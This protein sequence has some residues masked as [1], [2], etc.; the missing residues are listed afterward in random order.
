M[1][2]SQNLSDRFY[3]NHSAVVI[4]KRFLLIRSLRLLM[5]NKGNNNY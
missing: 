5:N 4:K 2:V 3:R 1:Y